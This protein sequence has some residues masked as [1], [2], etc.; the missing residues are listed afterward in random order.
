MEIKER[1]K[2]LYLPID[3]KV[4]SAIDEITGKDHLPPCQVAC[5][6]GTNIQ[7]TNILIS[8]LPTDTGIAY[9]EII[10]IGDEIY[11]KNPLF[12]I[13]GY[14]CGLCEK[15]CNYKDE[16]GS[17]RRR[18]LER[19]ISDYYLKYLDT[20]EKITANN[21]TKV[22]V[23]G[24]GPGGLMSAY[25]LGKKGYKVTIFERSSNL[26][27]AL[28]L[29]PEYRLPQDI[30]DSTIN[31]L[32][33][34]A[35][36]DVKTNIKIGGNGGKSINKL[37]E[38]GYRA[39]F[40]ATGTP[41]SRPLTF[42]REIVKGKDLE[43]VM[44]G[45]N[46]LFEVNQGRDF[47]YEFNGKKIVVIGGGN[48][49]FDVARSARRV[50][51]DVEIICLECED[52]SSK[53]GIP[54]D[55]EEIEGAI[56]EG[57]KINYSRGISKII[58]KK[59]K[60]NKVR[61]PKCSSVFDEK[62]FNPKFNVKDYV[63]I[64]GDI[65]IVTIGQF[66]ERQFFQEESL[67]NEKGRLEVD[68]IT[69]SSLKEGVFIGGDVKRIGFCAEAMRDGIESAESIDRHIKGED[70]KEGR[71]KE[72]EKTKIPLRK[73]YKPQT[74]VAW[75]RS[76]DRINSFDLFEKGFTIEEAINEAKRCLCCGPCKACKAC[77]E[78]GIQTEIPKI[79]VNKDI[80]SGC[81]IC[82]SVCNYEATKLETQEGHVIAVID[83][84]RCKRCGSC[85]SAC[86]S[87]A[88]QIKDNLF[89]TINSLY[90]TLPE[91]VTKGEVLI[92]DDEEIVRKSLS[93]WLKEAVYQVFS[94]EDG[95]EALETLTTRDVDVLLVDL[96]MPGIDG[97]EV[98]KKVKERDISKGVIIITAYGSIEN[99]VEAMKI[100]AS[101]YI[102]KPFEPEELE[103]VVDNVIEQAKREYAT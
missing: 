11:E 51:G 52:K 9:D 67:L 81:G 100:G 101:D 2:D 76:K 46:F 91:P 48:V 82:V 3:S 31:N 87:E 41:N 99:A 1:I 61:C 47:S 62:G 63:Y 22:A 16:G 18:L 5:P 93:E 32:V 65:L 66:P 49:A 17:I 95:Y 60:F 102:T 40:I 83:E 77:I 33:R 69:L 103:K 21:K 97:I 36:C 74:K 92:V 64:E 25:M 12:P 70:L 20:K 30:L 85:V 73:G 98:L 39:V 23:I 14:V 28:N 71:E 59:G 42:E 96:K 34:I 10:R 55:E 44:Q 75:Y 7:R 8:L 72:F 86:P 50:G 57:L 54:A 53:D 45:I 19:F 27:G 26:G 6:M 80:C 79:E 38:E 37:K 35:N 94:V 43:G 29:I 84:L 88:R 15:E 58:G 4:E 13:C 78:S 90:E 56:E 89:Q 68:P 24:G